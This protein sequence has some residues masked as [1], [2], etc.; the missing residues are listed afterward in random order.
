MSSLFDCPSCG[1]KHD[2]TDWIEFFNHDGDT[3]EF[4]C[5]QCEE[6]FS[7][8]PRVEVSYWPP[9]TMKRNLK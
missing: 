6:E 2:T 1:H 8:V 5:H 9:V 7:V 4:E 3:F